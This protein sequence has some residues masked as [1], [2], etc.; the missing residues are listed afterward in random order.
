VLSTASVPQGM[1]IESRMRMAELKGVPMLID[2]ARRLPDLRFVVVG[3]DDGCLPRG[4]GLLPANVE[5][6]GHLPLDELRRWYQRARVYV[7][8]SLTE[9][10]PGAVAE[11]MLCECVPVGSSVNGTPTLIGDTGFVVE[12][13]D[14]EEWAAM[15]TRAMASHTGG[16]ARERIV[17]H[18]SRER[19]CERLRHIVLA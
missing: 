17:Q 18:F 9:G 1:A 2:V 7:H 12:S 14:A 13:P 11:A 16:A 6:T 3:P 4:A 5:L 15:I 19:R 10:L 8:P